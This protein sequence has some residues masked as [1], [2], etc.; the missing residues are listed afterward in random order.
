MKETSGIK[1]FRIV[2]MLILIM[3]NLLHSGYTWWIVD[4]QIETGY[5]Y[6][7]NIEMGALFIWMFEFL[8]IPVFIVGLIYFIYCLAKKSSKK[9]MIINFSLYMLL[10]LQVFITNLFLFI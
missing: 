1:V 4:E 7:T 3:S 8:L 10:L 9:K 6:G 2:I 5:G